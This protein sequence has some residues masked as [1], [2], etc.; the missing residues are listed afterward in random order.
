MLRRARIAKAID[1]GADSALTLVTA[2]AGYGKTTAVSAWCEASGSA[3]AWVTL[4][5]L[6]NNPSRL[7]TYVAEAVDRTCHGLGNRTLR[8]LRGEPS[9]I[10]AALDE[11]TNA[12]ASCGRDLAI[13][14]DDAQIIG[15][16]QCLASIGYVVERLPPNA[17]L[18][19][20]TRANPAI[21]LA[22]L[23]PRGALTE[24]R[25]RE[26]AFTSDEAR[27]LLAGRADLG[28][29][30]RQIEFL[31]ERTEGWPAALYVAALWLRS[32]DDPSQALL[33]FTGKHPYITEYLSHEVL[34]VLDPDHRSFLLSVAVLGCFTAELCDA[35]IGC[36]DSAQL[37]TELEESNMFVSGLEHGEWFHVH[38]LFAEFAASRLESDRPG[39]VTQIHRRA[40]TWLGSRGMYVE[41]ATHA[42]LAADHDVVAKILSTSHLALIRSGRAGTLLRFAR[43]L[44]DETLLAHPTLA[45][46]TAA[47]ATLTGRH[48][49][50]RRRL[51]QLASRGIVRDSRRSG[52]YASALLAT[53]RAAGIDNGVAQAVRDGR[54]A[55]ALSVGD[56]EDDVLV[57]ALA[58]LARALYFA[59]DLDH[60]LDVA[61]RGAERPSST[62]RTPG[63]AMAQATLALIA[64]DQDRPDS[65][66]SHAEHARAIV[67]SITS[68]RSWLGGNA[69]VA[70]GA[71]LACGNDLPHAEHEFAVAETLLSDEVASIHHAHVLMTLA[72][73]RCRRGRIDEAAATLRQ[74]RDEIAELSDTGSLPA[75]AARA[76][77]RL[78]VARQQATHGDIVELPSTAEI[79]VLRLLSTDL[80]VRE[81]AAE[82]FLS[83]N[84]VRSHT[85]SLYR[86]LGVNSREA[87]VART[88]ALKLLDASAL[89]SAN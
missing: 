8:R 22:A 27:E 3:Y 1:A 69:A 78:G 14:L 26:L 85:R 61:L 58:A 77:R 86:K 39:A 66:R 25:T 89:T 41:A 75:M 45:A 87:A 55:V 74:A 56:A 32:V 11:L 81:I 83:T 62:Q 50:E 7:W 34:S 10:E 68:S 76:D 5:A 53:V 9:A 88:E 47:A 46:G 19:I 4:D 24:L 82:L 20:V 71:A 59:G 2:P 38:R 16:H 64:A 36:S 84:T 52:P 79:A 23:R 18:F 29:D 17:R 44:P 49:L 67:G 37:I 54:E 43:T 15:D 35:V 28:L 33:E 57:A 13:V 51:I 73:V 40:A 65:A 48:T 70:T 21:G 31:R 30:S 42:A 12:I 60:A 72:D 80:S 6:D 63:H